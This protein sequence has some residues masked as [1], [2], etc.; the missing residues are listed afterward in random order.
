MLQCVHRTFKSVTGIS[1]GRL[2]LF[3]LLV[4]IF[5]WLE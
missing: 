3:R 2:K 1:I 5:Q 4:N